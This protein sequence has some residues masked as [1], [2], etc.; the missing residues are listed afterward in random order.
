MSLAPPEIA[1]TD[2]RRTQS[3]ILVGLAC[4]V[5]WGFL[6]LLFAMLERVGSVTVVASRTVWSLLFVGA[7][8]LIG[9]RL[10][11]VRAALADRATLRSMIVSSVLLA[12]NWLIYVYAVESG[13]AL[14]G[15]F[16]YFVNPI[17]NVFIGM[18]LLG[19]RQNRVQ[20]VAIGIAIAAIGVQ[21]VGIGR[22]PYLALSIAVSFAIYGY[23]RKTAKVGSTTGLFVETVILL[24][25]ALAWLGWSF[26][27]D[28][29]LGIMADPGIFGLLAL[30][31]PATAVPLLLFAFAVQRLRLTTIGMLQYL[32]P[33]IQ[34]LLAIFVLREPTNW[35][36]LA[37]FAMI[38]LSLVV[39]SADSI[40]R[41]QR[42]VVA[43]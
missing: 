21:S 26:V 23:F 17:V 13:Q 19:E 41:R 22:I 30:T 1:E 37:S 40:M 28:G 2:T 29:G 11:E 10:G 12:A 39:Y 31:G 15:S 24:P 36:Q 33:S 6:P 7:I 35:I 16:G 8:L 4:Y 5:L 9:G 32:S 27:R 42:S 38:G 20:W 43:A 25:A 34:F 18:A 14:E 3:G